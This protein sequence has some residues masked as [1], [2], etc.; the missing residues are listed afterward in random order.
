MILPEPLAGEV[1]SLM[2]A[3]RTVDAVRLTRQQT[4]LGLLPALRA[5]QRA[6]T[7]EDRST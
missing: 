3:G 7:P 5:A 6:S 1:R 4:R 2:A